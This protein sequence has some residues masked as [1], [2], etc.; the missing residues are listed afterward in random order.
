M[1][2]KIRTIN[3]CSVSFVNLDE[4]RCTSDGSLF[5]LKVAKA[6]FG[7]LKDPTINYRGVTKTAYTV[8]GIH[9]WDFG[10]SHCFDVV[11]FS[12]Q[13]KELGTFFDPPTKSDGAVIRLMN[14]LSGFFSVSIGRK[15]NG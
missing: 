7:V 6:P 10:G 4:K 9:F 3:L 5:L 13:G 12:A 2:R 14:D 8:R 1:N 15:I 11:H